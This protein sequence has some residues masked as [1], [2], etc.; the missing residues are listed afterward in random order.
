MPEARR[1]TES[2]KKVE[3][4]RILDTIYPVTGNPAV[5]TNFITPNHGVTMYVH[6]TDPL[7]TYQQM[8][9]SYSNS[10][11]D[12]DIIWANFAPCPSCAR[13]LIARYNKDELQN[14][15]PT[16]Y[17]AR[18]VDYTQTEQNVSH[19]I[20]SLECLA[21][22]KHEG[23]QIEAWNYETFK[24]YNG[25]DAFLTTCNTVLEDYNDDGNFTEALS[26]LVRH[27]SFAQQLGDVANSWCTA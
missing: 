5:Y 20:Q 4:Q 15:K 17:I 25:G 19:V 8:L 12:I 24:T 9:N 14:E 6:E 21:K 7:T 16:I 26:D 13:T 23:F 1:T 11:N 3:L 27:V 2:L 10:L 22:L 18:L